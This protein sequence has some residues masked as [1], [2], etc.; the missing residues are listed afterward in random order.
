M[1]ADARD[2]LRR[3]PA[4]GAVSVVLRDHYTGEEIIAAVGRGGG[5]ED[6]FPGESEGEADLQALREL[7]RRKALLARQGRVCQ[8]LLADGAT[9][10]AIVAAH[11]G[12]LPDSPDAHRCV[13]L[14][15]ELGLPHAAGDPALVAGEGGPIPAAE[16]NPWLRRARLV[17]LSLE[18]NG[19]ICRSLLQV[20]YG[21]VDPTQEEVVA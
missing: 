17:A 2:A 13:E 20:R 12:E 1:V 15:R 9:P 16:L 19:G 21:V 8:Q 6:A 14:R 18:S 10:E 4:A 11:V 7:F 5:F 3:V